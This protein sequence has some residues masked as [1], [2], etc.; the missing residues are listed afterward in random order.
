[1][2]KS[3]TRNFRTNVYIASQNEILIAQSIGDWPLIRGALGW[4][5]TNRIQYP[6]VKMEI[7]YVRW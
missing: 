7:Y 2:H 3:V 5:T 6:D 4:A 1:M